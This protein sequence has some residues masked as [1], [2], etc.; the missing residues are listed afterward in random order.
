[1]WDWLDSGGPYS[2]GAAYPIIALMLL[3]AGAAMLYGGLL[4]LKT[5]TARIPIGPGDVKLS[6][7]RARAFGLGLCAAGLAALVGLATLVLR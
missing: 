6:G 1:M 3:I 4:A 5:G 2:R 7:R